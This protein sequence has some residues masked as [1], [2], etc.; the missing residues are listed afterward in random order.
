MYVSQEIIIVSMLVVLF[1]SLLSGY[2]VAFTISGVS[3][4]FALIGSA[5]EIFDLSFVS[6]L[7]NRI[8]GI[9]TN[10]LLISVPLF[11]FMGVMLQKSKIAEELLQS[12]GILMQNVRS[13]LTVS[14]TIVGALLAAST[15]IVG[16][17]VITMGLLSLPTMLK[18]GYSPTLATGTICA[19]GTLGQIIPPS[20]VLILLS[21]Q[22]SASYQQAQLALGNF[23]PEAVSVTD[24]FMGALI[25]GLVLV[26]LYVLWQIINSYINPGSI[27]IKQKK[28]FEKEAFKV[29]RSVLKA[30]LPPLILI[31]SVLGSILGGLA[32]PTESAGVGALGAIIL[33]FI[34]KQLSFNIF[35]QVVES[36]AK[37]TSMVFII[38]V[39]AALFS[40]VFR[41]YGGDEIVADFLTN[42]K[43]GVVISIII[44][45]VAIFILGFFL[46]VFEI[47]YVVV[48]I[49]G[50]AI[51]MMGVDPLWFAIMIAINLQTSFLTPPF[52]FALFYLRGVAPKKVLTTDIYK[53]AIP[54]VIIQL[55]MLVIL[56]FFPKLATLL[57]ELIYK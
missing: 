5:F 39:G 11:V 30:L 50:P 18:D 38:L 6:A 25:P 49:I 52:G 44:T 16:A 24:L 29:Y 41:G 12:M 37:T 21:D 15:G 36:T 42:I 43:G 9:M 53:G 13:G 17:T 22:I 33:A 14:V 4:L 10:D 51:L 40:L 3:L 47:I 46:E 26:F 28:N 57:P 54:F 32:T 8:Y 2:P 35:K 27:P 31:I 23:S 20:I 7:P 56:W 55:M 48:P 45:M 19:A 1:L 34:K